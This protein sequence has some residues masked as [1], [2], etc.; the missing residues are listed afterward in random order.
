VRLRVRARLHRPW[1]RFLDA[2]ITNLRHI[3]D[4]RDPNARREFPLL[5]L[6]DDVDM[7]VDWIEAI[8]GMFVELKL[9]V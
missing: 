1:H 6:Y 5:A 4:G 9:L 8:I 3:V 2:L 7:P